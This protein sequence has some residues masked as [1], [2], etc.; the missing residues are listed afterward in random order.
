MS[1]F[2][3]SIEDLEQVIRDYYND[4]IT[5]RNDIKI[6]IDNTT[7]E[8]YSQRKL[9]DLVIELNSVQSNYTH[10]KEMFIDKKKD[11]IIIDRINSNKVKPGKN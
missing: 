3:V 6:F 8:I 10:A 5:K 4:F 7:P 9:S 1:K 11:K 2:E